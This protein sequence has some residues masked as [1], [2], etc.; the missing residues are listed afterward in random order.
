LS[1]NN[2]TVIEECPL[3]IVSSDTTCNVPHRTITLHTTKDQ[4][5]SNKNHKVKR[6]ISFI[7]VTVHRKKGGKKIET[8][9][10]G[11]EGEE[12]DNCLLQRIVTQLSLS[13]FNNR[14]IY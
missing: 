1:L 10:K 5:N 4:H 6:M 9:E 7:E 3:E 13:A 12:I 11:R 8:D 14:K 2:Y